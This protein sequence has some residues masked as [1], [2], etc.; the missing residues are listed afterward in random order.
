MARRFNFE[1][2]LE[3]RRMRRFSEEFKRKKMRE[4]EQRKVTVSEICREYEVSQA[5][6]YRWIEKYG[7]KKKKAE[8]VIVESESDT[9]RLL[10]LKKRVAELERIVGQKQVLI[11]F[12]DKMIELAEEEYGV[13]IKKKFETKPSS[14]FGMKGKRLE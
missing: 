5:T 4:L 13:D 6:V 1:Q 8:R 11:D 14:A 9:Q 10:E 3:E 12:K 2:S 7:P